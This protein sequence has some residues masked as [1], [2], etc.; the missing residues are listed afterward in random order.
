MY[1]FHA[2]RARDFGLHYWKL[3]KESEEYGP[4][5]KQQYQEAQKRTQ[6]PGKINKIIYIIIWSDAR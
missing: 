6:R 2:L 3:F 1:M 5:Q 4:P